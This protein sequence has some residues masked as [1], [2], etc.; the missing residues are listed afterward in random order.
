M[1]GYSNSYINFYTKNSCCGSKSKGVQ[2]DQGENGNT[3]PR[4]PAGFQG[5]TGPQGAQG[6]QGNCCIGRTGPTGAAGPAGG[7]QGPTGA[8][9][10]GTIV[11][12]NIGSG[13]TTVPVSSS[14]NYIYYSDP[15]TITLTPNKKWAISWSIQEDVAISNSNFY[16]VFVDATTPANIYN[17][18][19]FNSGNNFYLNAGAGVTCGTGNDIIDLLA[20]A[21]TT[22]FIQ[23]WQGG[24]APTAVNLFFSIS[25]TQL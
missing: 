9:G 6:P 21:Q 5:V 25:L 3:G 4:G 8:A 2:G 15:T 12:F 16:I 10:T 22:F 1:S 19:V 18:I 13:S 14:S 11:N 24:G 17:P 20:T 7:A 23:L